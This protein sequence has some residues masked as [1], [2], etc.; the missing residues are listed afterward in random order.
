MLFPTLIMAVVAVVFVFIGYYKGHGEHITGL[1]SAFHM[2]ISILP[3]LVFA[4]IA[5]GMI[6]TLIPSEII[7]KWVGQESG[8][9][10]IFIGTIAGAI[11]PGGPYV[12]LPIAAGFIHTG[13]N[14]GTI[15]AFLTA[16]SLW[17]I[18]RI[19]MEVGILGWRITLIRITS[20]FIFPPIAGIIANTIFGGAK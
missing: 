1:Q 8:L 19:P 7:S 5:A 20:T 2:T 14:I 15:I 12:S 13:A 17:A 6:Q 3:L 10:G 18:T 9:R 4:F 16:W 11:T